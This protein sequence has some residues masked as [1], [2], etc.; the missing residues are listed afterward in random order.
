VSELSPAQIEMLLETR[1]RLQQL[2]SYAESGM[3]ASAVSLI[4]DQLLSTKSGGGGFIVGVMN[5]IQG[6]P[7]YVNLQDCLPALLHMAGYPAPRLFGQNGLY[8]NLP[9]HEQWPKSIAVLKGTIASLTALQSYADSDTSAGT[10][11]PQ[12]WCEVILWLKD[13]YCAN[14]SGSVRIFRESEAAATF[15]T[16]LNLNALWSLLEAHGVIGHKKSGHYVVEL[17]D[18]DTA[19]NNGILPLADDIRNIK[20]SIWS[21]AKAAV[22]PAA[23]DTELNR[24]RPVDYASSAPNANSAPV[25]MAP[26]EQAEPRR[27]KRKY[28]KNAQQKIAD[29]W[30]AVKKSGNEELIGQYLTG[31]E[32]KVAKDLFHVSRNTLRESEFY[33]TRDVEAADWRRRNNK[34]PAYISDL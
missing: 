12:D 6:T 24:T 34:P 25:V 15:P 10:E 4:K 13:R 32:A 17:P 16:L 14:D 1:S 23:G 5:S 9:P 31:A 2:L 30:A 19:T 26:K 29:H 20:P 8:P 22:N 21:F 3:K 27:A 11:L 7:L 18:T 28:T 33:K